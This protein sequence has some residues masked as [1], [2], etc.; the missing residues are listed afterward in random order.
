MCKSSSNKAKLFLFRGDV[1]SSCAE[2]PVPSLRAHSKNVP[3]PECARGLSS[4]SGRATSEQ[5]P[6]ILRSSLPSPQG[7]QLSWPV[8]LVSQTGTC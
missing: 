7:R 5:N 2:H 8:T 6:K 4:H 3:P 1:N